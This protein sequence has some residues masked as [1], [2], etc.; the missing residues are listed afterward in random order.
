MNVFEYADCDGTELAR[1]IASGETDAAEILDLAY[2]VIDRFDEQ[3]NAFVS[4]EKEQAYAATRTPISGPLGGVPIAMKDCV[5]FVKGTTRSFGSRLAAGSEIDFEDV[6]VTRF[7]QAGLI[8][9]GTTNVPEFSSSISTESLQ[10]GPCRNP[11]NL[12]CSV[13]GSSGGAAAAVAYGAV[14]IAY[15]NDAAGSIRIPASCC[16]VFGLRPSRG[17]VPTGPKFG[18]IWYG[19]M[20]HHVIT[21]SVRDSAF[22]LDRSEG[23]DSGAPYGAPDKENDY[24]TECDRVPRSLR[25]AFSDGREQGVSINAHCAVALAQTVE[26]LDKLGHK[27]RRASPSYLH[28]ELMEN[29]NTVISVALAEEIPAT[30]EQMNRKVGPNT[31]EACHLALMERGRSV[32]A[33]DLSRILT[34]RTNLG[35]IMGS[36]FEDYD[37]FLTPTI[38]EPPIRL[39]ILNTNSKD[40][41]GYLE[42]MWRYSP[43]TPLANLCGL[44][45]MSVPLCWT[46]DMLPIGMMF[47]GRYADEATLFQ[48]AGQ[49]EREQSWHGRH[50]PLSVWN[51]PAR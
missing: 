20:S 2:S 15:G 48:L 51:S 23:I 26:L 39:G 32:S 18:E 44:P 14:P 49:L 47:T 35:R 16:G 29:V 46:E 38:A 3:V 33:V 7:K 36:F 50:P 22:A 17:R 5:G 4:L 34:Y 8:P 42:R 45:S 31:V 40:L 24:T 25:I 41:E 43:F 28:S 11:W 6:V 13:G 1:R 10:H 19:L 12:N 37:L 27:M 9:I 30:A 21:R